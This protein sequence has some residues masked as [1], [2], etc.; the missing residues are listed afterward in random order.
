M[1]RFIYRSRTSLALPVPLAI[2]AARAPVTASATFIAEYL[3][4]DRDG[5]ARSFPFRRT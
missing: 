3:V 4:H 1:W 2:S 5:R